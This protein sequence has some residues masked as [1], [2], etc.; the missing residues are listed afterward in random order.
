MVDAYM[1]GAT[2]TPI[3]KRKGGMA[4]I[5]PDDLAAQCLNG[6]V[7]QTKTD[8]SEIE[9]VVMGCV[10]Q[11][12]E[13][14]L[15][16]GRM[17]V[18]AAG[19]PVSVPGTSVNRMCASSLQAANFAAQAV[20]AGAM[21]LTVGA[22]VE[23]MTRVNMGGDAGPISDQIQDRFDVIG[24]GLSA[25][26]IAE[27]YGLTRQTLDSLAVESHRRALHAID[28]GYFEKEIT[29]VTVPDPEGASVVLSV[30]EGPRR[31][32]TI[33]SVSGLKTPFREGGVI[34][35]ASSS[36]ISDGAAALLI[37]SKEKADELGLRARARVRSMA[38]SGSDP[39]MMLLAP[40]PATER[41]LKKAGLTLGDIDLFEVNE[42]FGSVVLAWE[43]M[44]GADLMERTNVNGGAM[45][46]GHPLGCSG[47]RLMVTLLH[48]MER[49]DVQFGLATL[50]IGF[51][52]AVATIIERV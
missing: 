28:N 38:V 6:L 49:R 20:M 40:A 46:L 9:D 27:K 13:Q 24:Q 17:A 43:K 2:R 14:G 16:I 11:I 42:A 7:D 12:G 18:L 23:S 52:Q 39:T 21:D 15:N 35:A 31:N 25:E 29:P 10:T 3:G 19:W 37:G 48:E 50:C 33:E 32:S 8:P 44:L 5:R 22:G 45:A 34:T 1:L 51:G 4:H 26:L 30:D 41:A 47:A 36:Q